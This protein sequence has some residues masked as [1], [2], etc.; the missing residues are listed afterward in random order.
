MLKQHLMPRV[1]LSTYALLSHST[2]L[3]SHSLRCVRSV[4]VACVFEQVHGGTE[5]V[6]TTA[7]APS[8]TIL[9]AFLIVEVTRLRVDTMEWS[10]A[11]LGK[12]S[13]PAATCT[14]QLLGAGAAQ[15]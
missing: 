11:L 10:R 5:L 2:Y 3:W 12:H 4:D 14:V 1:P 6:L 8:Y 7:A 15:W 13:R 9:E